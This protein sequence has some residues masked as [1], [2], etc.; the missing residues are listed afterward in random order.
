MRVDNDLFSKKVVDIIYLSL[1]NV[2]TTS[3]QFTAVFAGWELGASITAD[4]YN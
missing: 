4:F 3:N 2:Y 1:F